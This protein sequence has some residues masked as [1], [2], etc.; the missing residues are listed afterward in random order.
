MVMRIFMKLVTG[1]QVYAERDPWS[2]PQRPQWR[3]EHHELL[4]W[5][6]R[7]H[8]IWTPS[9]WTPPSAA[10]TVSAG[11]TDDGREICR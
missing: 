11:A 2:V 1:Q 3:T 6:G 5:I 10:A 4:F 8:V 9:R 7:W